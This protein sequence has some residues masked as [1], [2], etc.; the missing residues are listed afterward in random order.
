MA[1]AVDLAVDAIEVA[2]LVGVEI[3]AD[4]DAAG[5]TAED[6]VDEAVVLEE[7]GVVGVEGESGHAWMMQ[8]RGCGAR[9]YAGAQSSSR[10][11]IGWPGASRGLRNSAKP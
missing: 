2:D 7:P 5:A 11:I 8:D 6:R 1:A 9:N 3:H 10:T 4:R